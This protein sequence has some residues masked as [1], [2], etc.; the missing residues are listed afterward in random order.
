[1]EKFLVSFEPA[2]S[3]ITITTASESK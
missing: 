2:T 3:T 1:M